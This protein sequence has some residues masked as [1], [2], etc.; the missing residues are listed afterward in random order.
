MR[1]IFLKPTLLAFIAVVLFSSCASIVS[2]SSYPVSIRTNPAGAT[3]SITDK[4]GKEVYKGQSPATVTLKSGAGF[5]SKAEY[6]VKLSSTGFAEKIVPINF[7]LNG[8][9]FGNL[10][11]GGVVGM[12]II[13]PATGAMWKIQDP[14]IDENLVKSTA[15]IST[16]PTLNIVDIKDISKELRSHLVRLK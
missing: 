8:W 15:A 7:N 6:Q 1:R 16:T 10:L 12:L 2:K 4:K 13:D 3:V 5:F 9:Y 14:V 11:L